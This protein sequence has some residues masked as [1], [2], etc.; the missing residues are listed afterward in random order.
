MMLL[1]ALSTLAPAIARIDSLNAVYQG[2]ALERIFGP[3]LG[4][5]LLG[6]ILLIVRWRHSRTLDRAYAIGYGV[7]VSTQL[8]VIQFA[9]TPMWDQFA[10]YLLQ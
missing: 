8:L 9:R 2:T 7:L 10:S 5:L 6:A 3:S 4:M 1:A